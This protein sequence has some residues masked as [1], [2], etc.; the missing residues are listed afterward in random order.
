MGAELGPAAGIERALE[1][2][3]EDGRLDLAPVELGGVSKGGQLGLVEGDRGDVAEEAA[4]DVRDLLAPEVAAGGHLIHQVGDGL[5]ELGRGLRAEGEQLAEEALGEDAGVLGE[6][7]E[8]ELDQEVGDGV[9][10][11]ATGLERGGD[12]AELLGRDFGDVVGLVLIFERHRV[13]EDAEQDVAGFGL[14]DPADRDI[15]RDRLLVREVRIDPDQLGIGDDQ[16]GRI[17]ERV[18][19]AEELDVGAGQIAL[20]GLVLPAEKATFPDVGRAGAAGRLIDL[21]LEGVVEVGAVGG[22]G[23]GNAEEVAE[24][25]EVLLVGL[26][27]VAGGSGPLGFEFVWCHARMIPVGADSNLPLLS[28][29]QGYGA[30]GRA[31]AA[32]DLEG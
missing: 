32:L 25:G 27:L 9:G 11:L 29:D 18:H 14:V 31:G 16:E 3:A 19:V 10:L 22:G 2:G 13:G 1:K 23:F 26:A 30:D 4:V 7:A 8:E 15:D 5:A 12:R 17:F 28:W 20:L 6:E 24:V 21:F